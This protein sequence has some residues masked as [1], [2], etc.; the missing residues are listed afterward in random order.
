[1]DG[2]YKSS[3]STVLM[4]A[5][6]GVKRNYDLKSTYHYDEFRSLLVLPSKAVNL[7]GDKL[8]VQREGD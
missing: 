2:V 7:F 6:S 1:M 4:L 5:I 8:Q 3:Y